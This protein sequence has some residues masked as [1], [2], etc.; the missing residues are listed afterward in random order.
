VKR[1]AD[2]HL[3]ASARDIGKCE[4]V[5]RPVQV[6]QPRPGVAEPHAFIHGRESILRHAVAAVPHLNFELSFTS[7]DTDVDAARTRARR[8]AV[9]DRVFD[10][11]L[12]EQ[13]RDA[14][15]Q[16]VRIDVGADAETIV[17]ACLFDR[18]IRLQDLELFFQA[19]FLA[20]GSKARSL[21]DRSADRSSGRPPRH[22]FAS[23]SRSCAGC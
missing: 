12:Q 4:T 23:G 10:Q 15:I 18:K 1:D 22:R 7:K 3:K 13:V 8:D 14:C 17:E 9:A 6:R 2:R 21:A 16:D 19:D 5:R 11:R 20:L